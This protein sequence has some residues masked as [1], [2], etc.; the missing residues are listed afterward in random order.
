[1][2]LFNPFNN[3]PKSVK[4]DTDFPNFSGSKK[5]FKKFI[6]PRLRNTVQ[7]LAKNH[8]S[9]I[10]KCQ[11]CGVIKQKN[12]DA[13]HVHGK[14]R[15]VIIDQILDQYKTGDAYHVNLQEFEELFIKAHEPIE[16]VIRVL[17]KDCHREYDSQIKTDKA[18]PVK[19]KRSTSQPLSSTKG[20]RQGGKYNNTEIQIRLT[21]VAQHIPLEELDRLCNPEY[22]KQVFNNNYPIFV[23][24]PLN[25][26]SEIKQKAIKDH[27]N[28]ARWTWKYEFERDGYCYAVSTQWYNRN[29]DGV[30]K[31]LKKFSKA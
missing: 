16:E 2:K 29:D 15:N 28:I 19:K 3:T 30:E 1:M 8:K 13:A 31:W 12:L 25:S 27:N 5:E 14:E 23:R 26:P 11:Q 20:P 7:Y 10:G 6:G 22:S 4:A 24:L 18:K 21:E 17:C 9:K